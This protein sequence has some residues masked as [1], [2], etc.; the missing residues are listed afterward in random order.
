[1]KKNSTRYVQNRYCKI[2]DEAN[3]AFVIAKAIVEENAQLK[4]ELSREGYKTAEAYCFVE[5]L[6][7]LLKECKDK[8][9][10]CTRETYEL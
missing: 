1:M 9:K 6:K 2:I 10:Y 4:E 5:E 7:E 8:L 3:E